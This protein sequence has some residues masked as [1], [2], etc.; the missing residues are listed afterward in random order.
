MNPKLQRT[1]P[2]VVLAFVPTGLAVGLL[3]VA[4]TPRRLA[5]V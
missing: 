4:L 1:N 2:L 3:A 5:P